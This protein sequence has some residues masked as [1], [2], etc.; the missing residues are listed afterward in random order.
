MTKYKKLSDIE[1][2]N[3]KLNFITRINKP[4]Y[5]Q[6]SKE[7]K[8]PLRTLAQRASDDK[9]MKERDEYQNTL[10]DKVKGDVSQGT[11]RKIR[12]RRISFIKSIDLMLA[13]SLSKL[14][15]RAKNDILNLGIKD[16]DKLIR[17]REFLMGH[18]D[19]GSKVDSLTIN[20]NKPI[21]DMD[22]GE[23]EL[24]KGQLDKIKEGSVEEAKYV[25]VEEDE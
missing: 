5:K 17:L 2:D 16:I 11:L 24:L 7:F 12:K 18:S 14:T 3:I 21:E 20:L 6:L 19:T 25:V 22:E 4:T 1:W 23:R 8:V 15:G 13:Q 10:L 9:W